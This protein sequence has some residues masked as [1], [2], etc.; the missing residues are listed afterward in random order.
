MRFSKKHKMIAT[1]IGVVAILVATPIIYKNIN[2]NSIEDTNLSTTEEINKK[3][4]LK[5]KDKYEEISKYLDKN[6][7]LTKEELE[8]ITPDNKLSETD[9]YY[10]NLGLYSYKVYK[11]LRSIEINDKAEKVSV[12]YSYEDN[13]PVDALGINYYIKSKSGYINGIHSS[14]NKDLNTDLNYVTDIGS[15]SV[16]DQEKLVTYLL[17]N[18]K[19][20]ESY[21]AY[22]K[23]GKIVQRSVSF[24]TEEFE[25]FDKVQ[26]ERSG[27]EET[28]VKIDNCKL[29]FMHDKKMK[30]IYGL[31][32][33]DENN[34]FY[35]KSY[36]GD[37]PQIMGEE[38]NVS[39]TEIVSD[40]LEDQINLLNKLSE[41]IQES[42]PMANA[43]EIINENAS[44]DEI[45]IFSAEENY[46]DM[47]YLSDISYGSEE[48]PRD[49]TMEESISYVKSHI[50]E[51]I[52]EVNRIYIDNLGVMVVTYEQGNKIY[53]V[54]YINPYKT[55]ENGNTGNEYDRTRT[56]GI[57]IYEK[58]K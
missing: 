9:G 11:D 43:D 39:L 2:D 15:I 26:I 4:N 35:T 17:P 53:K 56:V 14:Y 50:G 10:D 1:A 37:S 21:K 3:I 25:K 20:K 47:E 45:Q 32:L 44:E 18:S 22:F 40:S 34:T 6:N 57:C 27:E 12:T 58:E 16:E 13:K 48:N 24:P 46:D 29:V 30:E 42:T 38:V 36:I 23:L 55:D 51:D 54:R 19:D 33:I 8:E 52:K 5:L 31:K 41:N 7:Q 49:L 28:V